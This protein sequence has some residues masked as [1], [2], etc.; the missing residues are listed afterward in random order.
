MKTKLGIFAEARKSVDRSRAA[1]KDQPASFFRLKEGL[2]MK[3][4]TEV[5]IWR[6]SKE[7]ETTQQAYVNL[8]SSFTEF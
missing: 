8:T 6:G 4:Q 1:E 7:M 5:D 3:G 2:R